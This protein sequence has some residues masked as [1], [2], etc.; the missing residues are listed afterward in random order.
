[1]LDVIA[2][3]AFSDNYIWVIREHGGAVAIIDPGDAAPVIEYLQQNALQPAAILITHGH[4]DH[5]GGIA[6]LKA[7]YPGLPVFGPRNEAISDLDTTLV[8]GDLVEIPG[9]DFRPQVLDVPGHTEGH[10]AY[11]APGALF[12][13]DT[14]FACGC[15]RVFSGTMAQLHAALNKISALPADTLLYC[16]HEYTLDNI[17]FARWVEPESLAL[18][19]RQQQAQQL[20]KTSQPTVPSLLSLELA[21]NPFLRADV[22]QVRM[23]AE[24][25]AGKSLDNAEAVF[26]ALRQWKDREYD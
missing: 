3:E 7:R 18:Q 14:L 10:I 1:M 16:A 19:Q 17:G 4:A 24:R 26:T 8:E 13:G 25:Y 12:C 11:T 20:R 21:T 9:L 2:V 22:E 23:A 15:G 5:V 6:G